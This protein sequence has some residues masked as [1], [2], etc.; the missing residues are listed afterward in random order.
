MFRA[1]PS[2]REGDARTRR[3]PAVRVV[4]AREA[5]LAHAHS[6][7]I[8]LSNNRTEKEA[9]E[10]LRVHDP[11]VR[12]P[13]KSGRRAL[14]EYFEIPRHLSRAFDLVRLPDGASEG[15]EVPDSLLDEVELVEVK[16][17]KKLLQNLPYGF[18]FGATANEF[19]LAALLGTR[20]KFC[21]VCLN[22]KSFGVHYL[23]LKELEPIIRTKRV[24]FQV[25][26]H[27][28]PRP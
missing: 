9:V 24:Q 10:Y 28:S 5:F 27:S 7:R 14:M 15:E 8:T 17:T 19:E 4:L 21:F 1:G 2:K 18:F 3:H 25:N 16:S 12:V 6:Y 13:D 23:S 26:L 20:F 22:P 11:R